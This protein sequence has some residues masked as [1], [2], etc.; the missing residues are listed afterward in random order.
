VNCSALSAWQ[1]QTVKLGSDGSTTP[2]RSIACT[3]Q[4]N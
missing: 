1:A 2:V 3:G 4:G